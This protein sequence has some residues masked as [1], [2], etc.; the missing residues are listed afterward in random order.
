VGWIPYARI[1]GG[2]TLATRNLEPGFALLVVGVSLSLIGDG[3][4]DKR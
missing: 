3:L 1:T 2:E 4:A